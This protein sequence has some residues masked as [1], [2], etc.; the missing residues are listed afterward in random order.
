MDEATDIR[1]PTLPPPEYIGPDG[2]APPPPPP[3]ALPPPA[4]PPPPLALPPRF[5]L[6]VVLGSG[7]KTL[8]EVSFAMVTAPTEPSESSPFLLWNAFTAF[9]VA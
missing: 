8:S 3:P 9:C 4:F 7:L 6:A 2:A 5:C 1:F